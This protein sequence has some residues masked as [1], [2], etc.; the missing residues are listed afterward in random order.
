VTGKL[1]RPLTKLVWKYYDYLSERIQHFTTNFSLPI[2]TA[3]CWCHATPPT[4][5]TWIL[6]YTIP[7]NPCTTH[8][9]SVMFLIWFCLDRIKVIAPAPLAIISTL[10][11]TILMTVIWFQ[12]IGLWGTFLLTEI[13]KLLQFFS[14]QKRPSLGRALQVPAVQC[15]F[16]FAPILCHYYQR[17]YRTKIMIQSYDFWINYFNATAIVG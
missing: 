8:Y 14:L 17:Y 1:Y 4:N 6:A 7:I 3:K 2:F 5:F 16:L 13:V 15:S 11:H 10:G 9:S 12:T